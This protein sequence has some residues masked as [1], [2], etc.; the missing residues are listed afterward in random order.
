MSDLITTS[1]EK[2]NEFYFLEKLAKDLG[3]IEAKIIET[4]NI[5]VEDRTILKCM[6]G[7]SSYGRKMICPP[8]APKVDEFR[9]MLK[10][11]KYAL[12]VKFRGKAEID[13]KVV[14]SFLR[15]QFD[16]SIPKKLKD[17]TSK[18]LS[19]WNEDKKRIHLAILELEKAAFNK[20]YTFAVGFSAGSCAWCDECNMEERSCIYPTMARFSEHAVGVNIKKTAEKAGMTISFPFKRNPEPTVLLLID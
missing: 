18:F 1:K 10:E 7:C 20:G 4:N 14:K 17:R 15:C 5:V 6:S 19:V 12:L 16:P 9:K 8:F 13:E 3:A 11:Y 2:L